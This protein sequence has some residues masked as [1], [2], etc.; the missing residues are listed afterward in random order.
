MEKAKVFKPTPGTLRALEALK[1]QDHP[2][3]MA[4]LNAG[5]TEAV[6]SAHLT[7]LARQGLV[8]SADVEV[9]VVV[10]RKVKSYVLTDAGHSYVAPAAPAVEA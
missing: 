2:V 10:T 8:E 4:E 7:A 3:T 9:Q 6:T 1:A 5:L